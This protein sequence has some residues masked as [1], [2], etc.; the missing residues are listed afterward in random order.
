MFIYFR[1]ENVKNE[2]RELKEIE[3][4]QAEAG[5]STLE[6]VIDKLFMNYSEE[7]CFEMDQRCVSK[8]CIPSSN[9]APMISHILE[10]IKKK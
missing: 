1:G 9:F 6:K 5:Q 3:L 10:V 8:L 2:S 4:M 7:I